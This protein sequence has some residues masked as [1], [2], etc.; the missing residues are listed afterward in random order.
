MEL[1]VEKFFESP[2]ELIGLLSGV[3]CVWLLI[4]QNMWTWPIGL[5]YAAVSVL[6]FFRAR[7]Y[8][9]VLLHLFYV[10]MNAY[11]WTYWLWGGSERRDAETL[12]VGFAPRAMWRA[13]C[14]SL[15]RF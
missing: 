1:L 10:G 3:L 9:D 2:F 12:A 7:L 6:V 14:S 15:M 5:L 8:A 11:G 4:R 13:R